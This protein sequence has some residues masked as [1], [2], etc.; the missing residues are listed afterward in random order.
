MRHPQFMPVA[1]IGLLFA[2]GSFMLSRAAQQSSSDTV[3]VSTIVSVETKHRQG[4][5]RDRSPG[6]HCSSGQE[7]AKS[8]RMDSAAGSSSQ[9]GIIPP[10]RRREYHESGFATG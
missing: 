10:D 7:S 3:P 9:S 8:N 4:H 6:R 2:A 5:S 1:L